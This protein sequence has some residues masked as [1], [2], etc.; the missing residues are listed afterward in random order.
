M[1]V[2]LYPYL[3]KYVMILRASSCCF[4]TEFSLEDQERRKAAVYFWLMSV[5]GNK[6]SLAT[7][8]SGG[9]IGLNNTVCQVDEKHLLGLFSLLSLFPK[10]P[11]L[12]RKIC[13]CAIYNFFEEMSPPASY[14]HF[15]I[16]LPFSL[17]AV[18]EACSIM[19]VIVTLCYKSIIFMQLSCHYLRPFDLK[20]A[21]P[22]HQISPRPVKT[23]GLWNAVQRRPGTRGVD[24]VCSLDL[25]C[26]WY[27][28]YVSQ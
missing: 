5:T 4:C 1:S 6:F 10:F 20:R 2:R 3:E 13:L 26:F 22:S 15:H 19:S 23:T 11:L 28:A 16:C 17:T 9:Y 27:W 14:L 24:W 21:F 8:T 18:V 12:C 25:A 7:D